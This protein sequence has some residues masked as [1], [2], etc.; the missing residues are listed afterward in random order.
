MFVRR[1]FLKPILAKMKNIRWCRTNRCNTVRRTVECSLRQCRPEGN[2]QGC[3]GNV[4][5]PFE[6]RLEIPSLKT[7]RRPDQSNWPWY[8][9][10][11]EVVRYSSWHTLI[12]N[13]RYNI[14]ITSRVIP[15]RTY[16][17][18]N[19]HG[20]RYFGEMIYSHTTQFILTTK[21]V[22]HINLDGILLQ[23]LEQRWLHIRGLQCVPLRGG[24]YW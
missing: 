12:P 4:W 5:A 8:K 7:D 10:S 9:V 14:H 3:K 22:R 24:K 23:L 21:Y 6:S 19:I 11:H 13:K 1:W 15:N 2:P 18:W 20:L 16:G 17:S